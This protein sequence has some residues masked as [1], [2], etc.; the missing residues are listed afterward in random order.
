MNDADDTAP[1]NPGYHL[2]AAEFPQP[3]CHQRAGARQI[4]HDF[5]VTMKIPSPLGDHILQFKK[6]FLD[7]NGRLLF[8]VRLE[9][10]DALLRSVAAFAHQ[11][12]MPGL[13]FF[14]AVGRGNIVGLVDRRWDR[15]GVTDM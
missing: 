9:T 15:S 14:V 10:G 13:D 6:S 1:G 12:Q 4:E 5:R 7:G 3:A 11:H 8:F 2:I